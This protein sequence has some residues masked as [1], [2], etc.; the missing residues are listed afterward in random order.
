MNNQSQISSSV[1]K[2]LQIFRG[3][4]GWVKAFW[5]IGVFTAF[6]VGG[7]Y[8]LPWVILAFTNFLYAAGLFAATCLVLFLAFNSNVQTAVIYGLDNLALKMRDI[9][10]NSNPFLT[11][12][13]A[14]SKLKKRRDE[15]KEAVGE[16]RGKR[17]QLFEQI[18]TFG[19]EL[20]DAK[21]AF[22]L[23]KK[24]TNNSQMMIQSSKG[25]RLKEAIEQ[26]TPMSE[27]LDTSYSFISKMYQVLDTKIL[28]EENSLEIAL[29]THN[30]MTTSAGAVRTAQRIMSGSDREIFDSAMQQISDRTYALVGEVEQFIDLTRPML[31]TSDF[32]Q[33]AKAMQALEEFQKWAQ[34]DTE[35]MPKAEKRQLLREAGVTQLLPA[36]TTVASPMVDEYNL[37]SK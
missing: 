31:E 10:L 16:L 23:A 21:G 22:E 4:E 12:R 32:E 25:R 13:N 33:Q 2:G 7:V 26:L 24:T 19:K 37:I 8:L 5:V 29:R 11:A 36:T 20:R 34:E 35:L 3:K 18:K 28:E 6:V 15:L 17:D 9:A 30:I 27:R 1:N 14:I